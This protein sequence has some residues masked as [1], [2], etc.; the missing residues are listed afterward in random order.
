M[1]YWILSI[2]LLIPAQAW[3]GPGIAVLE[4]GGEVGPATREA[5]VTPLSRRYQ[6]IDGETLRAKA[7]ELGIA[8]SRGPGLA[9]AA[10]KAGAVGVIAGAV[11][12]GQ[13]SLAV[14]SGETGE[15]VRT[16]RL[17]STGRLRGRALREALIV[18]LEGLRKCP[19]EVATPE[20]VPEAVAPEPITPDPVPAEPEP[21]P[22]PPAEPPAPAPVEE[23]GQ[24][25]LAYDP[26][27][28]TSSAASALPGADEEDPLARVRARGA[29]PAAPPAAAAAV[30][31]KPAPAQ[32]SGAPRLVAA[33]GFGAWSRSFGMHTN[34]DKYTPSPPDYSSGMAAAL[35]V[36]FKARPLAFVWDR[37]FLSALYTRAHFRTTVGLKSQSQYRDS[38]GAP[39][40]ETLGTSLWELT[41]EAGY[42]WKI[43]DRPT[44]PHLE[45]GL[46]YGMMD[47]ALDW[48]A[49]AT[50][51]MPSA[52]Y[53]FGLFGLGLELPFSSW[54]GAHGRFDYRLVTG[55][56]EIEDPAWYGPSS[57]GG[58]NMVVGLNGSYRGFTLRAEYSYT[59]YF[60]AFAEA[61][62]RATDC[63]T[64]GTCL[65]AAGGALDVL[66][67]VTAS[68]GYGF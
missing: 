60:Y 49:S 43:L 55:T 51:S 47:F 42:D 30:V 22:V 32:E 66:H 50:R 29:A 53:R 15:V 13:L 4:F 36:S 17:R 48:G 68:L 8:M 39:Q 26:G 65:K 34:D 62:S 2:G 11:S 64:G 37:G 59:R 61:T 20:P 27:A 44:S 14:F 52:A 35:A 19:A 67:G 58:V 5:L 63:R 31:A 25:D 18:I 1:R 24:S 6:I 56:G 9:R 33:V 21:V 45:L 10:R 54:I 40:T 3:A 28:D 7:A 57:T 23:P 16:E 12:G 41:F 38:G 46:G